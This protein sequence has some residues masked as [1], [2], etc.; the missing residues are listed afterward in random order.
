MTTKTR[1]TVP[2]EHNR[3]F[4]RDVETWFTPTVYPHTAERV[5]FPLG[6]IGTGNISVSSSGALVDWELFGRPGKGNMAPYSFF[7]LFVADDHGNA[8]TRVIEGPLRGPH[9]AANGHPPE[10]V[11]GVARFAAAEIRAA[12]PYV[13]VTMAC[14]RVRVT[15]EAFTPFVPLDL[16]SSAFPVAM[17]RY[18]VC[19]ITDAPL[20]VSVAGS[21]ANLAGMQAEYGVAG[22]PISNHGVNEVR[23]ARDWTGLFMYPERL[24]REDLRYGTIALSAHGRQVSVKPSWACHGH[25]AGIHDFLSDFSA[26]GGLRPARDDTSLPKS[27]L[28]AI[29]S[30]AAQGRLAPGECRPFE[31]V[32]GWCFPN[33][34]RD[35]PEDRWV[36]QY[37]SYPDARPPQM[38]LRHGRR[39]GDAWA[40]TAE[41]VSRLDELEGRSRTF[42]RAFY[43][44]T[45]P[46]ALI[47]SVGNSLTTLRSAICFV[48][49]QDTFYA[50]EGVNERHGSC[51]GNCTH[52][53]NYEQALGFLFPELSWSMRRTEFMVETDDDGR[54]AFRALR[55]MGLDRHNHRPAVDGQAGA[56]I[57]AYR[58]IM[59]NGSA[60]RLTEFWPRIRLAARYLLETWDTDGDGLPD[61]DQHCTYDTDLIGPNPYTALLCLAAYR[62]VELCARAVDDV[63]T[64]DVMRSAASHAAERI[65]ALLWNGRFY[66]QPRLER[67]FQYSCGCLADQ[68]FGLFMADGAGLP[69]LVPLTRRRAALRAVFQNNFVESQSSVMNPTRVFALPDEP[70]V[71]LCSWP[72]GERPPRPM[73]YSNEVWSGVEYHVAAGLLRAGLTEEAMTI[74]HAVRARYDGR[75]RNPFAEIEAGYHYARTLSSFGMLFAASGQTPHGP[76]FGKWERLSF[77]P[78]A[79]FTTHRRAFR[80]FYVTGESW[81]TYVR[82]ADGSEQL[83]PASGPPPQL[84]EI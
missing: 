47:E 81:G 49:A 59:K 45:L 23:T 84:H 42:T 38:L 13:W 52:V 3:P 16:D 9:D 51:S 11:P 66:S 20:S 67:P 82:G 62:A 32:L 1:H 2:L 79:G 61:S 34:V 7:A 15:I 29:G 53:W 44:S 46:T 8:E 27:R 14:N 30:V 5:A 10:R 80:C 31:F 35:W 77:N 28:P 17:L 63:E 83:V 54:M 6:G 41:A 68:L 22:V 18:Y 57:R 26:D 37:P 60:Q 12:Y 78:A 65:D 55:V 76:L 64:A 75:R 58:D 24:D 72:D 48:D 39:F 36:E 21:V 70:G 25:L 71:V 73:I 56:I 33:R 19:N 40:A 43:A 50:W 69:E 4:L 74:I